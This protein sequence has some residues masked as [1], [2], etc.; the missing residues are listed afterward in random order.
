MDGTKILSMSVENFYFLDSLNFMPMSLKNMP[1]T[2][3]LICKRG[4]YP[5]FLNTAN[6]LDYVGPYPEPK[7]YGD[8]FMSADDRAQFLAWYYEQKDKIFHKKEE[9]L[10]IA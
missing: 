5:H 2:F 6:N 9:L 1:K 4:Y 3:D 10:V 8:D 7:Y